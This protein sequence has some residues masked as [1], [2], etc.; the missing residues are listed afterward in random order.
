M[1]NETE[2][3]ILRLWAIKEPTTGSFFDG[4][5]QDTPEEAWEAKCWDLD[6]RKPLEERIKAF[7]SIGYKCVPVELR[8]I[9][10]EEEA[11]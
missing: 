9:S 11:G 7:E 5:L 8:E 4:T 10:E 6:P 2:L 1:T 3:K